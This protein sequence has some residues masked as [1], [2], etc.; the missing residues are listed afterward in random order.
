MNQKIYLV[1]W[2]W[3]VVLFSVSACMIVY[4]V[5][6]CTLPA[7]QRNVLQR[8]LKSTDHY[9]VQKLRLDFD[10]VGNF[11]V[12]TQI[13]RNATPYNFR[14]FLDEVVDRQ[15]KSNVNEKA[16]TQ[17]TIDGVNESRTDSIQTSDTT[18]PSYKKLMPNE[19]TW[20]ASGMEM[21]HMDGK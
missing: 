3:F 14:K 12:L 4:R 9:A 21:G 7:F 13:G 16:K 19:S 18:L 6:T 15:F 2:V 8:Y 20:N 5:L 11:F 17:K 1:L 10:H